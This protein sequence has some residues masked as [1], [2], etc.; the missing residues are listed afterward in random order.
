[1]SKLC[2][3]CEQPIV[4][5]HHNSVYCSLDCRADGQ[6]RDR[7][8]SGR[9]NARLRYSAARFQV[10]ERDGFRCVYCGTGAAESR[11]EL[12]HVTPKARG[13]TDE[14]ANLVTAC[15]SCNVGKGKKRIDKFDSVTVRRGAESAPPALRAM[16]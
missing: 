16:E 5:Q 12:D 3:L 4:G 9:R 11:L 1:M 7:N 6:R 15:R 2:K 8:A 10:F 14:I 13:G